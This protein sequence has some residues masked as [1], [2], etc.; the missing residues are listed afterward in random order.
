MKSGYFYDLHLIFQVPKFLGLT[1]SF[2]HLLI[3]FANSL[4]PAQ[5]QHSVIPDLDLKPFDANFFFF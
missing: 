3:T 1:H 2:C 5:D 4:D